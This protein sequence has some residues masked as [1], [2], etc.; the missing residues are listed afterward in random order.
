M[1]EAPIPSVTYHFDLFD[2]INV[3]KNF[4]LIVQGSEAKVYEGKFLHK[5][6]I[7]KERFVKKYRHPELDKT[8]TTERIKAEV[9]ALNRCLDIGIKCPAVYFADLQ[10]RCIVIQKI[11]NATTVKDILQT[12]F[13]EHGAA[14]INS[15]RPLALKI[16][17]GI[18]QMHKN[19]LVHGDLTTSNLL[20]KGDEISRIFSGS[21]FD[22]YFIDFGLSKRDVITEDKAVD[23]YVLER[24]IQSSH[25]DSEQFYN[26][27]L[28]SY[29]NTVG[30]QASAVSEKLD[31]VR[32]R[33]RKRTMVG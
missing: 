27:I 32:Q 22:V 1:S 4:D 28:E 13:K 16:G 15:L 20:L 19:E 30:D 14:S 8:L 3:R 7:L 11:P 26:F 5:N 24:A 31:D 17:A 6:S 9:R 18:A 33:G 21:E 12:Q 29:F 10:S 25:P 23:L 2:S